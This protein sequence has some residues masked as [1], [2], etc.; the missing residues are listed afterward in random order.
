MDEGEYTLALAVGERK[1]YSVANMSEARSN[2]P[3]RVVVQLLVLGLF[4][5]AAINYQAILDQYALLT[6]KPS[7]EVAAI[8]KRMALTQKARAILYRSQPQID[9]K[10]EFNRDCET[11][12]NELELGCYF[13]RRIYILR[14]DNPSLAPEM[15]VVMAHELLHAVWAG[16]SSGERS[17][18][19][20]ELQR[21]YSQTADDDLKQRM[22][23]YAKSEPGEETN[24]LHSIMATELAT[25][26]PVLEEHYAKYFTNRGAIVAAHAAYQGVFSSR[27]AELENELAMIRGLKGQ[28]GVINRQLESYRLSGQIEQYNALVPRQNNLVDDINRRIDAYRSGVEEYNALSKSLDSRE[29]TDTETNAQ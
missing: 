18:L 9:A 28:L 1:G 3:V 27:R 2:R 5:L 4:V 17:R 20:N 25:L 22:A 8:E 14:I 6:F 23:G 11:Q 24:E 13:H 26:S 16:L 15:D 10:A 29:I 7:A 19:G 21:L 12:V